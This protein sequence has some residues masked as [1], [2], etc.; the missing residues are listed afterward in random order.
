MANVSAVQAVWNFGTGGPGLTKLWFQE[1]LDP[2]ARQAGV[3]SARALLSSLVSVLRS[4]WNIQVQT[5]IQNYSLD[6]GQL[7]NEFTAGTTPP[8]INGTVATTAGYQL[9]VGA[10]ILWRTGVVLGGRKVV[11]RTFCVPLAAFTTSAGIVIAA[12][13]STVKTA[14]TAY[15]TQAGARP[16]VWHKVF[17]PPPAGGG[18]RPYQAGTAVPIVS[19]DM[20]SAPSSLRSRRY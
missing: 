15:A 20:L 13:Q 8:Q 18:P 10:R 19:G 2:T 4:D 7:V 1:L 14:T 11:G 3:D 6:T 16:I 9:G 17:G 12:L 5:L